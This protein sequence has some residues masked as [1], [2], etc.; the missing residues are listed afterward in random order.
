MARAGRTVTLTVATTVA[1]ALLVDVV[2]MLGRRVATWAVP[3][4]TLRATV[5]V[6]DLPAG[7]YVVRV[8]GGEALRLTVVR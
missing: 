5:V 4:G 2:D 8:P 1:E 7:A 6:P 3:G